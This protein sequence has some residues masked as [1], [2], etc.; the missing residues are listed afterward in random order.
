VLSAAALSPAEAAAALAPL[1][2]RSVLLAVSG[3]PDSTALLVLAARHCST[4]RLFAATVD[5]GLRPG[6][7]LEAEAVGRLS[8]MLGVRH[9]ILAWRGAKPDSGIEAAA[10]AERYRLL[11]AA[12]EAHGCTALATAHTLDDQAET[13]LLRL[14]A[15]S[16]PA[17]LAAMRPE[18]SRDG[19]RH[20]RPF[21][22][23]P[24]ARLL[25]TLAAEG[26]DYV[27]DP[28]NAEPGFAR[29][30]LRRAAAALAREG[31]TPRRLA[32]LARRMA[33]AEAALEAA[34]DAAFGEAATEAGGKIV[35]DAH[36]LLALPE[37]IALRV[38]GRAIAAAGGSEI[39]LARL[40]ALLD[41]VRGALAAE[42]PLGRTLAGAK[43]AV[44]AGGNGTVIVGAAPPRRAAT[45]A[46]PR[47]DRALQE[48]AGTPYLGKGG[49]GT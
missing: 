10:R 24:K 8:G 49:P 3:G 26:V 16:G 42:K 18:S 6:S 4:A 33:R 36:M 28:M 38:L 1:A 14:A 25:A 34:A 21:L 11:V 22:E 12:A 5:H 9:E 19:L 45:E 15:G 44:R 35:F 31:L 2:A 46:S 13:V 17:G 40:E 29:T 27:E 7:R 39:R 32:V 37:E 48:I 20:V 30:R 47:S 41:A 23:I 43:I